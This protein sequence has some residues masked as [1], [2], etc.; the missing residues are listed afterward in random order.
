M[1]SHCYLNTK[2]LLMKY[3]RGTNFAIKNLKK[4]NNGVCIPAQNN[5]CPKSMRTGHNS[6]NRSSTSELF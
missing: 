1:D 5:N 3:Q 4:L 2:E 6:G